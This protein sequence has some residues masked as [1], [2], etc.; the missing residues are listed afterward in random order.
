MTAYNRRTLLVGIAVA[1]LIGGGLSYLASSSPDGLE[2]TQADLGA[3]APPHP[4]VPAP[5]S[6]FQEYTLGWLG[7]GFWGNAAAG[8]IGSLLV[9]VILLGVGRLVR[10][11]KTTATHA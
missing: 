1:V 5:P 11:R 6:P 9:L 7:E 3:A 8:V 4:E 10:R 2:K